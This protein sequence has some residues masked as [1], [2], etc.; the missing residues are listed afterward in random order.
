MGAGQSELTSA[1]E[2]LD[3]ERKINL[4]ASNYIRGATFPELR[5]LSDPGYCSKLVIIASDIFNKRLTARQIQ[6]LSRRFTMSGKQEDF[7]DR[8]NVVYFLRSD[9]DKITVQN[10]IKRRN[11][12]V[13]IARFYVQIAHLFAAI[14]NTIR[15]YDMDNDG[16][17]GSS[18][19][20]SGLS[21]CDSR[22]YSL[23]TK[24]IDP[25]KIS[26]SSFFSS[27]SPDATI[28]PNVCKTEGSSSSNASITSIKAFQTLDKLYENLYQYAGDRIGKFEG[29]S[30]DM[31]Q[32][33][34]LNDVR[35]FYQLLHGREAPD[36]V[37][38]FSDIPLPDYSKLLPGCNGEN[39]IFKNSI[40]VNKQSN[41]FVEYS[42]HVKKMIS[43][44][45]ADRMALIKLLDD[46]FYVEPLTMEEIEQREA[47]QASSSSS[48][49]YLF[50]SSSSSDS[51]K[52]DKY[53]YNI[54]IHPELTETKLQTIV[55]MARVII[56]RLYTN[57]QKEF[58]TGLQLLEAIMHSANINISKETMKHV[59]QTTQQAQ[60][61]ILP[62]QSAQPSS[63]ENA[64][65]IHDKDRNNVDFFTAVDMKDYKM[66]KEK[67]E[68]LL[69]TIDTSSHSK[70]QSMMSDYMDKYKRY[71]S[72]VYDYRD[73]SLKY[74]ND[75]RK[76]R[77][78]LESLFMDE[79]SKV[80]KYEKEVQTILGR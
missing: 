60:A 44:T 41:V 37:R 59:A 32:K 78:L 79:K 65:S 35:M 42:N 47:K 23:F 66:I 14:M 51:S 70:R 13:G 74:A 3:F 71:I 53:R 72:K 38:K 12:C 21:F 10:P 7:F 8:D 57:C 16:G 43:R 69:S 15:P 68:R 2:Y 63:G 1:N 19:N 20:G 52:S 34:Y 80:D 64:I 26:R 56:V 40:R 6:F 75:E 28:E 25:Q 76:M 27:S 46:V 29:M 55:N 62:P 54:Y 24:E 36:V 45:R 49:A 17:S 58:A 31:E 22:I 48:S 67:Y 73:G 30:K 50:S 33:V 4:Y 9:L 39:A 5:K 18:S 11:M 61:Q 77:S